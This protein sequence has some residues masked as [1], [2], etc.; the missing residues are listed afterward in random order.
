MTDSPGLGFFS[1]GTA[2]ILDPII[3]CWDGAALHIVGYL[4]VSL[5][6]TL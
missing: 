5:P 3:L 4:A 2:D 1:L 6:P